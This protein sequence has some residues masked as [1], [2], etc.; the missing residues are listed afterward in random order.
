MVLATLDTAR[1]LGASTFGL[2]Q[3]RLVQDGAA[4][5]WSPLGVL[6]R[7]PSLRELRCRE[8]RACELGGDDLFLLDAVS[9]DAA[10][11][12]AARVPEGYPGHL[13]SVPHAGAGRLLYIRLHDDPKVVSEA[14]FPP[15][16]S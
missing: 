1:A 8:G 15:G 11:D 10:F 6:V 4:S 12:H 9:G 3:F 16:R 14:T 7:L 13:L 2:L 5:D